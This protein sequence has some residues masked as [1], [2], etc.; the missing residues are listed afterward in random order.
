MR[1]CFFGL[2]LLEGWLLHVSAWLTIRLELR[3]KADLEDEEIANEGA[4]RSC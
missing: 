4:S 2:A 1:L 3:D